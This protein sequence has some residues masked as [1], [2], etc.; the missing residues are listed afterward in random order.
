MLEIECRAVRPDQAPGDRS[1]KLGRAE[2]WD[3]LEIKDARPNAV[4]EFWAGDKNAARPSQCS[5]RQRG[6]AVNGRS[7]A[8]RHIDALADKVHTAI[9][10]DDLEVHLR[11]A[12]QEARQAC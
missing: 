1:G 3:S 6:V 10:R 5:H 8:Q 12:L 11:V 2:R 4:R 7:H 9:G